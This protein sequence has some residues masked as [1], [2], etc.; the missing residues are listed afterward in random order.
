MALVQHVSYDIAVAPKLHPLRDSLKE[1]VPWLWSEDI[2]KV[3]RMTKVKLV[4]NL[5]EGIMSRGKHGVGYLP[6]GSPNTLYCSVGWPL[7]K[8]GSR[9]THITLSPC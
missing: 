7:C 9:F 2:N 6:D 8:V 1:T 5:E 4:N 3:F